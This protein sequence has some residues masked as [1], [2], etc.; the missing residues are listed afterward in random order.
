MLSQRELRQK[1]YQTKLERL[2]RCTE[3]TF[4]IGILNTA[5]HVKIFIC[6]KKQS[7]SYILIIPAVGYIIIKSCDH[8]CR[9]GII[10]IMVTELSQ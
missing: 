9:N 3:M 4:R 1:D 8:L 10:R 2:C 6:H 5:S 7:N